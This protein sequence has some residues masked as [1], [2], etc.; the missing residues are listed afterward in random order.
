ML[1]DHSWL[2]GMKEQDVD[3]YEQLLPAEDPLLDALELIPWESF[4][5]AIESHYSPDVGQPAINPL[6]M[7]KLEFLRY[8]RRLSDREVIARSRTDVLFR[9][10]L[11]IPVHFRLPAP[12]SLVN[13][14]G[15]LGVDGFQQIFD[16]L[17]TAARQA[18]LVRDR[19]RLKDASHM[20]AKIS[21]PSTIKLVAQIRDQLLF[22]IA[23]LEPNAAEGFKIEIDRMREDTRGASD[24]IRLQQRVEVLCSVVDWLGEKLNSLPPQERGAWAEADEALALAV[25]ILGDTTEPGNGDRTLS[26]VDPDARRGKHGQWYDGYSIDLMMDADSGLITAVD[27]YAA[28]GDE[29]KNAV[30]LVETEQHAQGNKVESLSIDGVGFN[31]PMLRE[32]EDPNGLAITVFTPPREISDPTLLSV[33]QFELSADGKKVTCP[34]GHQS[35]TRQRDNARHRTYFQF[36]RQTC[37]SCPLMPQCKPE[38]G[39]GR[40]G[41]RG[42][43][44]NDY[45]REHQRA[46]ERSKTRAYEA[47]R[48]EHPSVE[49]KI[50]QVVNHQGGRRAKY[51]GRPKSKIQGLMTCFVVNIKQMLNL[52]KQ[53]RMLA[54]VS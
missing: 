1:V 29:A 7:L 48:R 11:Q 34:A 17:I 6:L 54:G 9:Y 52:L 21:V 3:F 41:G 10:F 50:N 35:S 49:R 18:G 38:L 39:K 31:G 27:V 46:R 45:E 15:R 12:T 36:A 19:L 51:W 16:E 40:Y 53:Q 14:R 37:A 22:R 5:P 26:V 42:V 43:T 44:K 25:K 32:L 28:G 8:Y 4:L 2:H 47:T 24:E 13:F 33:D 23:K 30:N 20:I